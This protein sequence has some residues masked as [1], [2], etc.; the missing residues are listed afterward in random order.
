LNRVRTYDPGNRILDT[1]PVIILR[2]DRNLKCEFAN[3]YWTEF[4]GVAS[5]AVQ[6]YEWME[7][8]AL[9]DRKNFKDPMSAKSI[10][11]SSVILKLRAKEGQ[12]FDHR[13]NI[14]PQYDFDRSLKGYIAVLFDHERPS[15][16]E[17]LE[18]YRSF[19]EDMPQMAFIANPDGD[20]IYFNRRWYEYVDGM[21]G[22][23]GWGWKEKP[24]HHPDDLQR[25]VDLWS[26][27]LKTGEDYEIEYRLRRFD[28]TYRWHLGKARP[29]LNSAGEI[30]LWMGTN[31][32][33]HRQKMAEIRGQE[34]NEVLEKKNNQLQQ[35]NHLHQDLL[36]LISHDLRSPLANMALTIEL[37]DQK[38]ES[39][40]F[41]G[42]KARMLGMIAH[43]KN[44]LDGLGD[45]IEIQSMNELGS[46]EVDFSRILERVMSNFTTLIEE[47]GASIES[48]FEN[49]PS[50]SHIPGFVESIF[51]N[52]ISNS[53]KYRCPERPLI[54]RISSGTF[55]DYTWLRFEDN[56][57]GMDLEKH[58]KDLFN[59]FKRFTDRAEGKGIG[60][61][62]IKNLIEKNGGHI[63]VSSQTH[64]GTSF[65]CYLRPYQ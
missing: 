6:G 2:L 26:H 31:T 46:A 20:I 55:E 48:H 27:A 41:E 63:D 45:M 18:L 56:G 43:Q 23:E 42:L 29:I 50:I 51:Q 15:D 61:Y 32:D 10:P 35:I 9:E 16:E 62:I 64:Q 33:I 14:L 34:L 52:L 57:I 53:L 3:R 65:T 58:K 37:L 4:T 38:D 11:P 36:H 30:E 60:L 7:Y 13:M 28:G 21:E 17:S 49:Q 47:Y 19:T 44:I 59:P 1:L 22:T 25:T 12:F 8:I 39:I 40:E 5:I 24:I 54:I